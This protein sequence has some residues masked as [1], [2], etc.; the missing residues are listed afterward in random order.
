MKKKNDVENVTDTK[1]KSGKTKK[2]KNA[3]VG[4]SGISKFMVGGLIVVIVVMVAGLGVLGWLQFARQQALSEGRLADVIANQQATLIDEH[5]GYARKLTAQIA[6]SGVARPGDASAI[7][8]M[9]PSAEVLLIPASQL[10]LPDTMSFSARALIQQARKEE[11]PVVAVLPASVPLLHVAALMPNNNVVLLS[12]KMERIKGLIESQ[13]NN[14]A[15]IQVMV[16]NAKL[17][18][19]GNVTEGQSASVGADAGITVK[20]TIPPG[21]NDP[22]LLILFA[23]VGGGMVA[24]IILT[25]VSTLLSINRGLRKDSALLV[26][27]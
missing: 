9:L 19:V 14:A 7:T 12:W 24:L 25:L 6:A 17:L 13:N 2:E 15:H 18:E 20:V 26:H 27:L 1:T 10:L 8:E 11:K 23:A 3:V 22:A 21:A 5:I 4:A 16:D